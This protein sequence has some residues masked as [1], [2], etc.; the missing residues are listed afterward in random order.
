[1]S[2]HYFC[3]LFLK[4]ELSSN[5]VP[6]FNLTLHYF[7]QLEIE[8]NSQTEI[9]QLIKVWLFLVEWYEQIIINDADID[10]SFLVEWHEQ[11]IINDV[12]ISIY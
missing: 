12:D 1:M 8:V 7:A 9:E 4:T 6:L 2:T 3:I 5:T 10:G 11:I